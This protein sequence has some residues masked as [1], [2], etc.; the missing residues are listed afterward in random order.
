MGSESVLEIEMISS[1]L[2]ILRVRT[3]P[4]LSFFLSVPYRVG[5]MVG[6]I[7]Y[8]VCTGKWNDEL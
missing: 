7:Y 8:P 4:N 1:S 3:G 6:P 5:A 2:S